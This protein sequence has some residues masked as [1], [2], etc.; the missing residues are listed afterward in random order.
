MKSQTKSCPSRKVPERPGRMLSGAPLQPKTAISR[1]LTPISEDSRPQ[2]PANRSPLYQNDLP[3]RADSRLAFAYYESLF[4]ICESCN[5]LPLLAF[6]NFP[7]RR[8]S[9]RGLSECQPLV[10]RIWNHLCPRGFLRL[11]SGVTTLPW[12]D[13]LFLA[14][15]R[16]EDLVV[17]PFQRKQELDLFFH[18]RAPPD[19]YCLQVGC[20]TMGLTESSYILRSRRALAVARHRSMVDRAGGFPSAIHPA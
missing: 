12:P 17:D 2:L 13:D 1:N 14:L 7:A 9:S 5:R 11:R 20:T 8:R 4:G 16:Q 6:E 19:G 18:R 10:L 15:L 3:P